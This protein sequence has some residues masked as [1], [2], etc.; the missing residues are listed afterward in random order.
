MAQPSVA[1]EPSMEE[2]LASIRRII[3]SNEPGAVK[4]EEQTFPATFPSDS[5]DDE[6]LPAHEDEEIHLTIEDDLPSF[7][8]PV[9]AQPRAISPTQPRTPTPSASI[10]VAANVESQQAPRRVEEPRSISLADVAARVRAA[11]EQ[12]PV[13]VIRSV[14][15]SRG[16]AEERVSTPSRTHEQ[17]RPVELRAAAEPQTARS[18]ETVAH[19]VP[20]VQTPASIMDSLDAARQAAKVQ[21]QPVE[22]TAVPD[23]VS[24][25]QVA[26]ERH[27]PRLS[28]VHY[29]DEI[30]TQGFEAKSLVSTSTGDQVA[31]SFHELAELVNMTA[32]RTLDEVAEELLRP[33]LQEWLD[34][35]LPTLVE[36]LV[37]E[38]IERVARGP[39]R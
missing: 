21:T 35:N 36:R 14:E 10:P 19:A 7:A 5:Y 2:I 8:A 11:S 6:T 22:P 32:Q 30:E 13:E 29:A 15:P 17:G 39:R 1:R 37:R 28:D 9:N 12:R 26:V 27:L 24:V 16:V 25:S 4:G 33:M 34:D 3:E 38:E 20:P 18:D 23:A 31:R